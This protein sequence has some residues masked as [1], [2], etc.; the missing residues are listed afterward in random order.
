LQSR[1]KAA[2]KE[3]KKH[4]TQAEPNVLIDRLETRLIN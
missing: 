2:Q 4:L 3:T 1:L